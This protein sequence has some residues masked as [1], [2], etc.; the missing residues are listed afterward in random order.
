MNFNATQRTIEEVLN[1]PKRY[2][3]PRFQREYSWKIDEIDELWKDI[4]LGLKY[5]DGKL[6]TTDYFIGS[7]VLVGAQD[8]NVLKIVDGQQRLTT[9]TILLSALVH[10]CDHIGEDKIAK[11]SYTYIEGI[12]KDSEP[13][14][15]LDNERSSN[16]IKQTIQ[17]RETEKIAPKGIEQNNLMNAYKF[18]EKKFYSK[19]IVADVNYFT[20]ANKNSESKVEELECIKAVRDQVLAFKTI[21]IIEPD[22]NEAYSIFETLNAKGLD[23]STADLIKN[24]V[25]KELSNVHPID[26]AKVQWEKM[27]KNLYQRENQIDAK[28]FIR[29]YWISKYEHVA[30]AK[31]YRS[32]T[33]NIQRTQQDMKIF[34]EDLVAQSKYYKM[35]SSP[36][37]E[38]WNNKNVKQIYKSLR[39]LN[40]MRIVSPR[41]LIL[42]LFENY[43]RGE[44]SA[45][46]L[47]KAI[48]A[49][50]DF[51][52]LFSAVCS[53]SASG[54]ES[55]YSRFA[56]EIRKAETKQKKHKKIDQLVEEL[57]NK[58]PEFDEFYNR[59]AERLVFSDE[60][61]K[62][63]KTIQYFFQR[64]ESHLLGNDELD[65]SNMSLE[66]IGPQMNKDDFIYTIGN[67]IP[68]H[69]DINSKCGNKA[70]GLKVDYYK[71][72]NFH[73]VKHFL[74]EL[75]TS[76]SW[77]ED[78]INKRT[79]K[80]AKIAYDEIFDLK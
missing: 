45:K 50:E 7:L 46:Y 58:R 70:L 37:V 57:I 51:H 62:E 19:E 59:F 79:K 63:K 73:S 29:H 6:T 75:G 60:Y 11:G 77:N 23:L 27:K 35:I 66:H 5:V 15:R 4:M 71:R 30:E 24:Q 3:V 39:A 47:T 42:S 17:N 2:V 54:L 20:N 74:S 61:T 41:S 33:K 48:K 56:R 53:A 16:F 26:Y 52:F 8:D 69:P 25:F 72:S 10:Y 43:Y 67:M 68:L 78:D 55:K 21:Y 34:L 31:V 18:F 80:L 13:Y 38:D 9:I 76:T 64:L 32:F 12:T 44:I 1:M 65:M 28:I 40:L 22:E 36:N 14:F 49:I